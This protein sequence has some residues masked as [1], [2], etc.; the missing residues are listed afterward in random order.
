VAAG[1]LAGQ[2]SGFQ[3]QELSGSF[4]SWRLEAALRAAKMAAATFSDFLLVKPALRREKLRFSF[5]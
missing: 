2:Q 1:F 5:L 4:A 3:P